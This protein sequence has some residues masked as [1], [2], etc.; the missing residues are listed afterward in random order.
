MP[1]SIRRERSSRTDP[2]ARCALPACHGTAEHRDGGCWS[3][4]RQVASEFPVEGSTLERYADRFTRHR[5]QQLV[6]SPAS[7]HHL[8]ALARQHAGRVPFLGQAA[9]GHHARAQA[10]RLRGAAGAVYRTSRS[11]RPEKLAVVLVQLPPKLLLFD[12]ENAARF[13]RALAS[14]SSA[15]I[16]CEPRHPSWFAG[17]AEALLA[18]HR[19][20]RVVADPAVCEAPS[21]EPRRVAGARLLAPA[22]LADD[23]PL[24]LCRL[25]CRIMRRCSKCGPLR[26]TMHGAFSTIRPRQPGSRRRSRADGDAC[27]N[28][29]L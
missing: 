2:P 3:I 11:A 22:R 4:P 12:G 15:M 13:F 1:G 10:H 25:A 24:Q 28:W 20:A 23:V 19:V 27:L 14:R 26:A 18:A 16:A 21:A 8:G 29:P 5:D 17:E 9:Q 7:A 6:L